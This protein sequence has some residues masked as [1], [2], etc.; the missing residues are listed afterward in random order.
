MEWTHKC[1]LDWLKER[2]QFI[3]ASDIKKLLPVTAT[4]RKRDVSDLDRL[5]VMSSKMVTLTEDDCWS[6]GAAARGHLLEPY[7]VDSLNKM[8][9]KKGETERFYWWDD[10]LV[11]LPD[12]KLA[13]SPDAMNV[14]MTDDDV[15]E[16]VS[17]IA[18]IKSY[19]A[20]K[21]LTLAY[22]PK[23]RIEERWQIA[24]AMALLDNI[25][26]AYLVLFNPK[27]KRRKTF[28]IRFDRDELSEEIKVI[29]EV[30][31]EWENFLLTGPLTTRPSNGMIWSTCG[32]TEE[33][34]MREVSRKQ[35]LNPRV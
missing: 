4:G 20:E 11:T 1:D 18:E 32:G 17:A 13:F 19:S 33:N 14:P 25:D 35:K 23:D 2:Q 30:E 29:R 6:Y 21:H 8:L 24:S 7:A 27:M 34:I 26:H 15:I 12:R 5:K 9:E 10:K 31:E 22:M 28:V 16:Y 3:T